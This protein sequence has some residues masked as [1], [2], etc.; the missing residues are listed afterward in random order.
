MSFF[1]QQRQKHK[2]PDPPQSG[3]TN[4]PL[5]AIAEYNIGNSGNTV[6]TDSNNTVNDSSTYDKAR[7]NEFNRSTFSGP[8]AIGVP[9]VCI[10]IGQHFFR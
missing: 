7:H 8:V 4:R 10:A 5:D 9:I 6:T 1:G 3:L 2:Q